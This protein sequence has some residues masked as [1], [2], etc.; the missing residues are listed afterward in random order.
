GYL[1]YIYPGVDLWDGKKMLE[2]A[3]EVHTITTASGHQYYGAGLPILY[4]KLA[5]IV[6]FDGKLTVVLT[7]LWILAMHFL[8]FRNAKLALASVIPLGVGLL[9]MLG[10]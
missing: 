8:D 5:R 9:M 2:F 6:L 7:A 4:A 10:L 1:T 3:D